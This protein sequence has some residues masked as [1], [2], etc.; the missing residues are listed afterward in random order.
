MVRRAKF[1]LVYAPEAISHLDAVQAKYHSLIR[2]TIHE[3]LTQTPDKPTRNRKPLRGIVI[4]GASWELRFGPGNRIRV[5]YQIDTTEK[6]VQ[7]LAIGMKT[8]NQLIVGGEE[9]QL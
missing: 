5:F 8:G 6:V 2:R 9:V 3:Q 4:A 1:A 7:V